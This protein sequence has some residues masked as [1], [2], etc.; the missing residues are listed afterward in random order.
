[1][2]AFVDRHPS[3]L[4]NAGR[5]LLWAMRGWVQAAAKRS[6]PTM[7][8]HRGFN[9]TGLTAALT[10]FHVA[11]LV[12]HRDALEMPRLGQMGCCRIHEDEAVLLSL[13]HAVARGDEGSVVG[14]L[15]HLVKDTSAKSVV[16]AMTKCSTHMTLAGFDLT[17]LHAAK[18]EE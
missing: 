11:M 10:D 17:E 3:V 7:A 4:G 18:I 8:L 12:L 13:W 14:M 15:T 2:Y 9:G 5:F 6:C 16:R 1:M